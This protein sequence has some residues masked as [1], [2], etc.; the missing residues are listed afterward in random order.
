MGESKDQSCSVREMMIPRMKLAMAMVED[1]EPLPDEWDLEYEWKNNATGEFVNSISKRYFHK[2]Q[3]QTS[4]LH[5]WIWW[6]KSDL[7]YSKG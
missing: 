6:N 5:E 3:D 2:T 1:I 7:S 4:P